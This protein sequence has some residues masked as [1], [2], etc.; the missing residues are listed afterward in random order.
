MKGLFALFA[1]GLIGALPLAAEA[2]SLATPYLTGAGVLVRVDRRVVTLPSGR[3]SAALS[4][5]FLLLSSDQGVSWRQ[6]FRSER[7]WRLSARSAS[8]IW[9]GY[10]CGAESACFSHSEDRG[11]TWASVDLD[12][13]YAAMALYAAPNG[14]DIF[15]DLGLGDDRPENVLGLRLSNDG[16][17]TF[18]VISIPIVPTGAADAVTGHEPARL[19]AA[20]DVYSFVYA[21]RR[22]YVSRDRGATWALA[23]TL[24]TVAPLEACETQFD[25]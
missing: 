5:D 12:V 15:T 11:A 17:R 10:R 14:Q 20:G 6:I 25:L 16:G 21:D 1:L 9:I 18:R 8:Q 24:D 4:G 3:V 23:G 13:A 2:G 22:V 19:C 7:I